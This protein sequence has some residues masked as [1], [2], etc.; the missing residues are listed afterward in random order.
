MRVF[1]GI[2]SLAAAA[3]LLLF[4]ACFNQ[5][6]PYEPYLSR[7]AKPAPDWYGVVELWHVVS[8]KPYQGGVTELLTARAA[9]YNALH[10]GVHIQVAGLS[11][12]AFFERL[13]RG[14][15]PHGYSFQGGLLYREQLSPLPLSPPAYV[16]AL[17]PAHSE[18]GE[19]LAVPWYYSGYA[20]AV[21]TTQLYGLG[22]T[23]P[24]KVDAA[25][26][27]SLMNEASGRGGVFA[28]EV[29]AASMKLT[30]ELGSRE[31]FMAG[32]LAAGIIDLYSCGV[33]ERGGGGGNFVAELLPYVEYTD[34]V[35]Y[36]GIS[37]RADDKRAA[38]LA[39]FISTMLSPD[40][41]RRLAALGLMP[42]AAET[43][44]VLYGADL[45][46]DYYAASRG[47]SAPEAFAYQRH[48]SA[49]LSDAA[50]AVRGEAGGEEAFFERFE[51][52]LGRKS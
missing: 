23:M 35:Q 43:P 6:A 30:G 42:A 16:G 14:E 5:R 48:S 46:T 13:G 47:I 28:P 22:L 36:F 49:L 25:F 4:P 24:E 8:S 27:Q 31:D 20:L 21:N 2:V 44:D 26:L 10:P 34:Q 38:V 29:I 39:D 52:V 17:R 37:R 3:F 41:Q 18:G 1:R 7:F 11:E 15:V 19:I 32:K 40:E 9:A 51:V 45:L 12:T 33:L 50:R